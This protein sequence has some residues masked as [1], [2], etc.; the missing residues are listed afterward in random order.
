M[1]KTRLNTIILV[2]LFTLSLFLIS[3]TLLNTNI[4]LF[5]SISLSE[6]DESEE[7]IL[8][9]IIVPKEILI[10]YSEKTHTI[11]NID[12]EYGLWNKAKDV[13]ENTFSVQDIS[14]N[15]IE[16]NEYIDANNKKSIKFE[17]ADKIPMDVFL[18]SFNIDVDIVTFQNIN[19]IKE[20]YI[21]LDEE[22][23]IILSDDE[24]HIELK[25]IEY[26]KK[27]FSNAL[28]QIKTSQSFVNYWPSDVSLGINSNIYIPYRLPHEKKDIIVEND[29][30]VKESTESNKN[31]DKIAEGFFDKDLS[32]LRKVVDNTGVVIYMYNQHTGL[33]IY[34]NGLVEYSNTLNKKQGKRDINES[35]NSLA[36]FI[37][38]RDRLPENSYIS[39]IEAIESEDD[40]KGY[41]FTINYSINGK[42][43]YINDKTKEDGS[44]INALVAEVYGD[45]VTSYK[46]FYRD[47]IVSENSTYGEERI[48]PE[49]V[50]EKNIAKIKESFNDEQNTIASNM[51]TKFYKDIIA[52][53][54]DISL[55]Y[56]DKSSS[57][58]KT[59]LIESWIIDI[60]NNRYIFDSSSGNLIDI[61]SLE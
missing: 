13:L 43:V 16:E 8:S 7:I 38:K 53:I 46:R 35:L 51:Q 11:L 58:Y 47:I 37:T 12:N 59:P 2:S 30:K 57:Y 27:I 48:N 14:I 20:I 50:I 49:D 17:F 1:N 24:S 22:N 21:G 9:Q 5:S 28:E 18:N 23:N 6:Q 19:S 29:I 42:S 45:K 52:S 41:R 39:D 15:L 61:K 4:D 54:K 10:N 55:G 60:K 40:S 36:E 44:L 34:P 31:I 33:L 26:S 25:N 56:Y 32:Y 3:Q